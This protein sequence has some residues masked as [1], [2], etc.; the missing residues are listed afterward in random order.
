M[1]E[2]KLSHRNPEVISYIINEVKKKIGELSLVRG[3]G[4]AFLVMNIEIKYSMIQVNMVKQLEE[5]INFLVR[6]SV[7]WSHILKQRI[8]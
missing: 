6:T 1:Y 4:H 5:C 7:C 3:G 8:F 2:K